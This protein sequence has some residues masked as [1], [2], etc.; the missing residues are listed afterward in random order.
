MI[1]KTPRPRVPV[2]GASA[3]DDASIPAIT[4]AYEASRTVGSGEAGAPAPQMA[5]SVSAVFD[6]PRTTP[7][8]C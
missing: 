7:T 4:M 6:G 1:P 5:D 8:A 3:S 2:A